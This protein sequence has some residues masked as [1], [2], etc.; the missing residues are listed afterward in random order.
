MIPNAEKAKHIDREQRFGETVQ[1][2]ESYYKM[3]G[4]I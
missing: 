3:I 2:V 4:Y 1:K